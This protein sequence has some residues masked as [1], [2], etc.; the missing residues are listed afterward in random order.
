MS[1]HEAESN[2]AIHRARAAF[3]R[4][5][6]AAVLRELDA[7]AAIAKPAL[8]L[9]A[10]G[11]NAA[12]RAGFLERARGWLEQLCLAQP[13]QGQFIRLLSTTHNNLATRRWQAGDVSG[14][15]AGF[16]QALTVWPDNPEA[17]FNRARLAIE[18]RQQ[19]RAL[20][21]LDRLVVLR[22][23]DPA[24]A[25]LRAETRISL[26]AGAGDP[27]AELRA[28]VG[29]DGLRAIDPLRTALALADGDAS[30]AAAALALQQS[31]PDRLLGIAD[32][33]YRLAENSAAAAARKVYAHAA[34][35]AGRRAPGLYARIAANLSLPQVYADAHAMTAA[36]AGFS[37]GLDALEEAFGAT[38]LAASE[39]LLEQLAWSNQLLAYQGLDDRTL[40]VRYAGLLERGA[41]GFAPDL[42][43]RPRDSG[44][45]RR[46]IGFVSA[47]FRNSTIGA[48]FARWIASTTR[49]GHETVVVQLPPAWDATTERIGASASRLLRPQ[50]SLRD[51]AQQISAQSLDLLIYPDLGVDGRISVLAALRLA[52]RQVMA[53]GHPS[54]FGLSTIDA[55]LSCAAMEPAHAERHYAEPLLTLPGI[56][57][58]Y[59][60]PAPAPPIAR[61]ALGLPA[62]RCY[63]VPQSPS[64]VHPDTDAVLAAIAAADPDGSIVLFQGER[65]GT[66]RVLQTRLARALRE[67]GA[68]PQRQLCFLPMT[69]RPRFLAICAG[70]SVMVDTP[71][72]SGGNTT[73][74]ALLSGLPVVALPGSLMRGRQS[75]A[76]LE[77]VGIPE[78]VCSAPELQVQQALAIARDAEY[79]K[80]LRA[81]IDAGLDTMLDGRAAL[82]ALQTHI[83]TLLAAPAAD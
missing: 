76:M 57:T 63:L 26:G 52:P 81:R 3:A 67:A 20:V 30:E 24:A 36:R 35:L 54:T 72:W 8:E 51:L 7:F 32:V 42:R 12:L 83:E 21:D 19:A 18:A 65:P 55:V 82:A 50:G 27:Q 17:L 59:L 78:L 45:S 9:L 1:S 22:P 10:I 43:V 47:A 56:G 15:A 68:D 58:D 38:A 11:V 80:S 46:R 62:G 29:I 75:A 40:V 4:G 16:A 49:A 25:L 48:Y 71:H 28:A 53:W 61:E 2:E 73:I 39:P 60:R 77:R 33:A 31:A 14:A 23:Q 70:S 5:D 79:R 41:K 34:T 44:G 37:A 74:D 66:T 69:D 6:D 13:R 64:K